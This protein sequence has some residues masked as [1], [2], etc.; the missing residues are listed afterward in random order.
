MRNGFVRKVVLSAG[1]L[2][3]ALCA[4]AET[5][6]LA[7]WTFDEP[8]ASAWSSYHST[9]VRIE[10]GVLKG[11]M[12]GN[13][14]FI[15]SPVFP[16]AINA[17]A[18]QTVEMRVRTTS[19]GKG[20]L[21]WIKEGE[22][23]PQGSY[24]VVVEWNGD[25]AWHEYRVNPYWQC[26]QRISRFRIDFAPPP[27]NSGTYE[28]DWV[29]L[30]ET[31]L[32]TSVARAWSGATLE[33]WNAVDG[34]TAALDGD[35]L[36]V[37]SAAGEVGTLVSPVLNVPSQE[38]YIVAL[39]MA[40]TE[41]GTCCIQW[42]SDAVSGLHSKTFNIRPDGVL[43]VYNMDM[44]GDKNWQGN[45]VLLK[46]VPVDHAGASARIRSVVMAD[47]PQGGANVVVLPARMSD[48]INRAGQG[49]PVQFQFSNMGGR[50]A[51]NVTLAVDALPQGVR[52]VSESGWERVPKVSTSGAI[53]T[54][55]VMLEA[56]AAVSGD[57]VFAVSGD[58]A[59][60]QAAVVRLEILPDLN[61]SPAAYVPVPQPLA[62]DYEIGAF[63]FPGWQTIDRWARIWPVAPERKPVLG[64]Y[65]ETNVE[66]VDWQIKWAVENGL[67]YFLMDWYWNK[68]V[69]FN[70]HWVKVFKQ[71]R[72]R[73][74]L[75]W[76][77]MWAN[78]N[79][80]GSHSEND[81]RAVTQFWIDEYFN[82]PEYYRIDNKPVVVIW[83]ALEM[84]RDLG[85]GGCRRLLDISRALAIEAGYDGIYF[86]AIML[87]DDALN[88]ATL[89]QYQSAGFDMTSLYGYRS[90]GGNAETPNRYSF[91]HVA[92]TST[93]QWMGQ[94]AAGILPFLPHL[95]TGWDARPWD[96]SSSCVE[97]YGRTVGHFRRICQDAKDFADAT[98]I[99]RL[100]LGPLNEWGEGS[101][102]EP[103]TE[104]GFGM[105]EAVRETF[106]AM[107]VGGW[108]LNYGPKDVGLGPYDLPLADD[109][110]WSW[111]FANGEQGWSAIMGISGFQTGVGG[112]SFTSATRDP[113]IR[114]SF[115][116]AVPAK[117]VVRVV[118]R[119]KVTD[120]VPGSACQLFWTNGGAPASEGAS[121]SLPI[122]T[123]GQFHDYVFE[124]SR[125][126]LWN[127]PIRLLRFDPTNRQDVSVMI[128][129]IRLVPV[130]RG[131]VLGIR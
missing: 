103:N 56:A 4:K 131:T 80:G 10:N 92:N 32:T 53:R 49:I 112:L 44:S 51:R 15:L 24:N 30:V 9:N 3:V 60:G 124:V 33:E 97:V 6:V 70:D 102:A 20:N 87:A 78:H 36:S 19:G 26:Q 23:V 83:S 50:D 27:G 28:V 130:S 106:C 88:P 79:G 13:D 31:A 121:M 21:F 127:G 14:P 2:C 122:Q 116:I 123:D 90:H 57:A 72:Y 95:A 38:A 81:Q 126:Q 67:S 99:T 109:D 42:A 62:S 22:S 101:Y 71:A 115:D 120:V 43:H 110:E 96:N 41:G 125:H 114:R 107:P 118:V 68:G 65:D 84:D 86:I 1:M 77:V 94:Y 98:G 111:V 47:E 45:I 113:A 63:Y 59:D 100:T 37:V 74:Y 46:I 104:F 48:A 119:M 5:R 91:E 128:E 34:A 105:Y 64:W 52:V 61:L 12:T 85:A 35:A 93:N 82:M 75:K 18:G 7:E 8:N 89:Q 69:Q 129:S 39:E 29:R 58:G 117:Q 25:N 17:T 76:A 108:P 73:S 40:A 16:V 54:H 55:T 66:V 11:T